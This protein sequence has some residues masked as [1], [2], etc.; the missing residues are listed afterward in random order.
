MD[1]QFEQNTK[2]LF[3]PSVS[4]SVCGISIQISTSCFLEA[5]LT[6]PLFPE[7]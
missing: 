3:F 2:T 6:V 7:C 1:Q 4:V 5:F